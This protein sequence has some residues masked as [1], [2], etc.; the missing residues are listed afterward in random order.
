MMAKRVGQSA[1][2]CVRKPTVQRDCPRGKVRVRGRCI[3]P[4]G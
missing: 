1:F 2:R 4:A 3:Q